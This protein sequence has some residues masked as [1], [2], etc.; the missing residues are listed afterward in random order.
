VINITKSE[1]LQALADNAQEAADKESEMEQLERDANRI[2]EEIKLASHNWL[3]NQPIRSHDDIAKKYAKET[4]ISLSE[5]K[6]NLFEY[7]KKYE[8]EGK[9][10]PDLIKDMR[11]F[12]RT[13]KGENKITFT[14]SIDTLIKEYSNYLDNC[15]DSIY[16]VK[17]Y[18][19]P[20]KEMNYNEDKLIKLNS[21]TSEKQKRQVIDILCKYWEARLEIKDIPYNS[22]YSKLSK[23]MSKLK[24]QFTS[25]MKETPHSYSP[26]ETIKKSIL[27][28]VCNNPGISARQLHDSLPRNLYDKTSPQIIAKIAKEEN[29]TSVDGAYYK[30]NDDIKKNIW[31][32][33]AAFIDSDGYITMDKNHNPRVGLVATGDRGKAFMKEMHKSLGIGRLHLDQK[34]PQDTRLINRLN[35]YSGGEIK[36][37]L[38]KCL[39]HFK[40]KKNNARVL[41]ELLKIKKEN[42]KE[43]WFSLRKTELFKLMK[44]YN[45]SDNTR[46]DWK[47]WDIDIDGITKLEENSKMDF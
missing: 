14:E 40:L 12:R 15:V 44:Y 11:G 16:W 32:Y 10:I 13:L 36:K 31:A 33:T 24:K 30:I 21:I 22:E 8:I 6:K 26:K 7:P 35:F 25:V 9:S 45:H 46:F 42:K 34:S 28:S 39:P 27:D 41:L 18:K 43:D 17:K 38:T 5:A 29:I 4:E 23:N 47:A 2:K 37:L 20:L 19:I 3:Q 1:R